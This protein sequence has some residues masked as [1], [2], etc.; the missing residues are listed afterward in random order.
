MYMYVH[1]RAQVSTYG[2]QPLWLKF[3]AIGPCLLQA[4][5]LRRKPHQIV[6][7]LTSVVE[8]HARDKSGVTALWYE[9]QQGHVLVVESLLSA[10]G[11][12]DTSLEITAQNAEGR[13]ALNIAASGGH[14]KVVRALLR[15]DLAVQAFH[16]DARGWLPIEHAV[17]ATYAGVSTKIARRIV[18]DLAITATPSS[19]ED[20]HAFLQAASEVGHTNMVKHLL[21]ISKKPAFEDRYDSRRYH[22]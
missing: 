16:R 9:S 7:M 15:S 3:V 12:S 8:L 22:D 13:T 6:Q 20:F 2:G 10:Y 18:R 4:T 14:E 19:A 1:E 5:Q 11:D 17:F 21:S